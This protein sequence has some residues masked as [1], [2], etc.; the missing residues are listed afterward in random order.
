MDKDF[1][2]R[3]D[4]VASINERRS[5]WAFMRFGYYLATSDIII[6]DDYYPQIY[7]PDYPPDVKVIQAWHACGAFKT[8]GLERMG[9]PG[10]P[11]L[12]TPHS[13]VL[14]PCAGELRA[15]CPAQR[16]GLW[17]GREQILSGR[18]AAHGYFL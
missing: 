16:G 15:F 10:A 4:F 7:L 8:V 11:K 2:F 18:G 6:L 3:Y 1:I 5:L 17:L 9:K 13:Q 12:N 14:H